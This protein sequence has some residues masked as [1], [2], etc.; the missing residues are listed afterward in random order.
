LYAQILTIAAGSTA[1]STMRFAAAISRAG[2]WTQETAFFNSVTGSVA[3][4]HDVRLPMLVPVSGSVAGIGGRGLN[5]GTH[6]NRRVCRSSR[7]RYGN[8]RA[9]L[10]EAADE[11]V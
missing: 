3:E 1:Q 9:S 11:R 6:L 8:R 5:E 2:V 10:I 7:A 4:I